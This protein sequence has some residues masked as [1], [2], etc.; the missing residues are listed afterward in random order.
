[1]TSSRTLEGLSTHVMLSGLT[2][3]APAMILATSTSKPA[4]SPSR[5]LRPKP[6]WSYFVPTLIVPA[7]AILAIVVFASNL[8]LS[9]TDVAS[10]LPEP[11][12]LRVRAAT[13]RPAA[14]V[15]RRCPIVLFLLDWGGRADARM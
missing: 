1:M 3:M 5:P 8:G 14:T 6:G 7:A 15:F 10:P 2:P 11:H 13:A 4:S 12:A 9:A